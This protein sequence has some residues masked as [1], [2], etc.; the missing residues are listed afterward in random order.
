[1]ANAIDV[2]I[3][4]AGLSGIMAGKVLVENGKNV[5]LLDKGRSVGGRCAT[6]R[7]SAGRAD[8]GA[9]FFTCRTPEFQEY[10]DAWLEQG[11]IFE[12][13][14]GW[15]DGSLS[16]SRDGHSR[17]AV[18]DGMNAL[19][20]FLADGLDAHLN[21]QI[22]GVSQTSDGW[23]V[24]DDDGNKFYAR[25]LLMTPPVPQTLN[26]LKNGGVALPPEVQT[27]LE[28][29]TY[30]PCVV[31]LIHVNGEISLPEPGVMQRPHANIYW[32]ADNQAKGI[33]AT[34]ILT[35]QAGV[36]YSHQLFDLTDDEILRKFRVDLEP[37]MGTDWTIVEA[38]IKRWSYSQPAQT[39]A[40]R[41]L[42]I[43]A[44]LPSGET[45][46]LGLAGDAFGGPRVEGAF[47]SGLAAGS[48]LLK[49]L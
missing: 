35:L 11:I 9:Q 17:Y 25:A 39:Y 45:A 26:L 29:L 4:G 2:A 48:E 8:T 13:S 42:I 23:A 19:P 38:Q 30:D 5:V 36:A 3:I 27:A 46:I 18:S 37:L 28:N 12:W 32:I 47:L 40:E 44:A 31:G 24:E 43:D 6:R 10:I 1:M 34:K 20:K 49:R 15:S 7:M 21:T 14:R 16:D 22:V 33:S 41:C